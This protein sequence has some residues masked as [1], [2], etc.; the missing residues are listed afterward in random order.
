MFNRFQR[1]YNSIKIAT[2]VFMLA[3]AFGLA[4]ATRYYAF[5]DPV[6]PLGDT[7]VTLGMVLVI[8]P[9]TFHQSRLYV[10]NRSR[11]H[12]AEVFE[13]FKATI[14]ATLIIVGLTY[15]T[16]E[17]YS[18]LTLGFF[19]VYAFVLVSATR[20][21]FRQTLNEI[22]KRGYNLRSILLIGAGELGQRVIDTIEVHRE[23]GFR[24][25]GILSRHPR[26][27][28]T[29]IKDIP[30]VGHISEV[31]SVL[32]RSR[33]DQVLIALP[34]EDQGLVKQLMEQL[35]LRTVDVKVVPDLYQYITLC[36][37]LE[38]FGG[39]PII[40]LQSSPL[41]GWNLIAKRLFDFLLAL[42]AI[43]I[44]GPLMLVIAALIKLTSPGPVLFRQER[45]GMD[46]KTF[47]ILKF[48][49]MD[50]AAEVSG[51]K[52]AIRDDPR[53]TPLG[54]FL[55]RISLDELPQLFNV[56]IGDM[57]LVGPR[58]ERPVFIEEFKRQI[59]KYHLRHKVKSGITGWAQVNGLRGQTSIQKRIEYDLYYIENWSL[60]LDLKILVRTALGG[61]L[62]KNAY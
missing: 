25:T 23:L 24:I 42:C 43:L 56:L 12:I 14:I 58:P 4:Y 55:R 5:A 57:S 54:A 26:K 35:A 51:V 40:S 13:I 10:T 18:R 44:T 61:F 28:G 20:L 22:R 36:G 27:V 2:D 3:I 49:T 53:R 15:F 31:E 34:I 9:L 16:R 21:A 11:T 60:L 30:V 29:S 39:L 38:E 1:F 32:D 17:R 48:R 52:M 50:T 47:D 41:D 59:P 46:G 37:G 62:S 7:L 19:A 33:V 6:L 8:F 45:M